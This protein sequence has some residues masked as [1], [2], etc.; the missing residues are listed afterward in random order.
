MQ[1]IDRYS[2]QILFH[3]IGAEGQKKIGRS[4][5][6]IVGMGALGT[7]IANHLV[8]SGVGFVRIID[9]DLVELSNLQRQSLYTEQDALGHIP[10]VIAAQRKLKEINS[11]VEIEAILTDLN[12]ENA[13]ELLKDVNVI[14][15]GTDN[16]A[17]RYL[18]ND[19]AIKWGIPWVYGG[20]VS[21]RGMFAAII[22]GK[23]PCYRC[24]FPDIPAGL[25]ETCD[26]IG[27]LSSI[28][29]IIGS[30]Q[31]VE[32]IKILVG[33]QTNPN[34]EQLDI[35]HSSY[36][37]MDV[38]NGKNPSCPAC[39]QQQFD[40]LDRSSDRQT[41]YTS[42]C[43]RNT[44]QINPRNGLDLDF[45]KTAARLKASGEVE[46]NSF[47]LRFYPDEYVTM[48]FFQTG[49]ALIHG[50]ND[51]ATAKSYYSRYIGN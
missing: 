5:V 2:R 44:V 8:R 11:M 9:R 33:A 31:A 25:G 42:L 29:D 4:R 28:T 7:V 48:V 27:V 6:A 12:V 51:I 22:P 15:D 14:I 30:F 35:W 21:S 20:A 43:G 26:T 37:Q 1:Q 36:L 46:F 23:T 13:E 40:F 38:S 41:V 16:F 45:E 50:T 19:V 34:L 24:L 39:V 18:M 3:P 49:R 32:A 17:T 10:K 47:L